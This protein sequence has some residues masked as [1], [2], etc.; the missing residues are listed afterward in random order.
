MSDLKL[1]QNNPL[2][3]GFSDDELTW[4]LEA[5]ETR[6]F[7]FGDILCTAGEKPGGLI[8]V[9]E[10][11]VRLF[12]G[13]AGGGEI[14][15]G[16]KK[17]GEC[18]AEFGAIANVTIDYSARSSGKTR[19]LLIDRNSINTLFAQSADAQRTETFKKS[20]LL[21]A[22]GGLVATMFG[23]KPGVSDI[24]TGLVQSIGVKSVK[25]GEHI[26]HQGDA[27]DRRLYVVRK[28]RVLLQLENAT[29]TPVNIS[30]VG[31]GET[32]GE[33]S[34]IN[35]SPQPASAIAETDVVLLIIPHR[36]VGE[37]IHL[38]LDLREVLDQRAQRLIKDISLQKDLIEQGKKSKGSLFL[39]GKSI[40]GQRVLK[41]FSLIEQ[42]E[43]MDCGATCLAMICKHYGLSISRGKLREMVNT[44][45]E[46]ATLDSLAKV[47]ESLGFNVQG[48]RCSFDVL[49][50]FELPFIA[51]WEGYHYVVVHGIS[52]NRV[53]VADPSLGFVEY[54]REEFEKGWE[55]ICLQF[56][57][58]AEQLEKKKSEHSTTSPWTHFLKLLVPQ[59]KTLILVLLVTFLIELLSLVPPMVVQ[60]I[61]DTVLVYESSQLLFFLIGA[62]VAT[63]FLSQIT[64]L[65]RAYFFNF[66]I[67]KLDYAMVSGFYRHAFALPLSYF[68]TR[69]TGDIVARF[70]ENEKI[71][72]FLTDSTITTILNVLMLF[73]YLA[74]LIGYSMKLTLLLLATV[75]PLVALTLLVTP[76]FKKYSREQFAT[77]TEAESLLIETLS[78]AETVKAMGIERPQR[79]KWE[80][81]YLK[82]LGVR[83]RSA[84][85]E[86]Y[87]EF[88]SGLFN[89]ISSIIVLAVG[90]KMVIDQ[91]L[92]IG[93][94]MAF[95]MLSGQVMQRMM[96]LVGMWD[97]I[98]DAG[99]SMERL[100]DVLD[101]E[102]EQS[103][104][105]LETLI[106]LPDMQGS[107]Q[108][109]NVGFR[110][111]GDNH[112][113]AV[114][115]NVSFNVEAGESIAIVGQS[116]S[117]KT[118]LA[119]LLIG[120]FEPQD[121]GTIKVDGYDLQRIDM[122]TLR[123][124]VGYVMQ[125]NLLFSGSIAE[126][127]SLG[128]D[129]QDMGRI[130]EVAKL[131]DAHHFI[132]KLPNG[133]EQVV[134]ERGVGLSGGQ[135]QRL[136]IAR[137]LYRDPRILIFDEATSALD[138]QSEGNIVKNLQEVLQGR[139]SIVIAHRLSTIRN[140]D[141]IIVMYAG[142]IAEMG[143][144]DELIETPGM[145]YQ[146]I[147]NQLSPDAVAEET[148]ET[149]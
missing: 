119:K 65:L 35:K 98:H 3:S 5:G 41:R 108:V 39:G 110:Y 12:R 96:E 143:S 87:V 21:A 6:Q 147:K 25:A 77:E 4:L 149:A 144:H 64:T 50:D 115:H 117:G 74:V 70:Q 63:H 131:A 84:Q 82:A 97:E 22:M 133:Y 86:A 81:K 112:A 33:H 71:R 93:Q 24:N 26:V 116:G 72:S 88:F 73:I 32:F 54:T 101:L 19:V 99:V 95:N 1:L 102:P 145:Y 146:L 109:E 67:R 83:Y 28:G 75:V 126:N 123:K 13:L 31:E 62:L 27:A 105:E 148:E 36:T 137:A 20:V 140:A 58:N 79:M 132:D 16:V 85:F 49:S 44:T 11:A 2:F 34:C 48:V 52:K 47:G 142:G 89:A 61:L 51:H 120:F 23:F 114:L 43:Q 138:T 55:G 100:R 59:R 90:S 45:L 18:L 8:F 134:G 111:P 135:V 30:K 38:N 129:T 124:K 136:C 10:G 53:W 68:I 103:P 106:Q 29:E 17:K 15:L 104:Q 107:I 9:M 76:K 42:A 40:A 37:I 46:G 128:S 113:P 56:S 7:G 122:G 14:N 66:I 127:I 92:S 141:R 118:T 69:R 94:L 80:R 91:Q 139:T 78:G 121:G 60:Q 130:V 57:F 125:S